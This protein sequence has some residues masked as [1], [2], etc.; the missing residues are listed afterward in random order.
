MRPDDPEL[1]AIAEAIAD[2]DHV[3]WPSMQKSAR[4]HASTVPLRELKNVAAIAAAFRRAYDEGE[5]ALASHSDI[6]LGDV[7]A[8]AGRASP[9]KPSGESE[10][11]G[12]LIVLERIAGGAFGTVYRAWDPALDHEVALKRV[13]VSATMA[14]STVAEVVREG[15]LLA[16]V[17]HENVITVHGAREMD[18]EI[19]IWMDF[20]HGRTLDQI[21]KDDGPLSGEEAIVMA[22]SL[23][24]A[25]AAVH[26]ADLLHRDIKAA[27]VMRESGGRIVML[28]FGAGTDLSTGPEAGRL[29]GTPLYMAPELF[30]RQP[31]SIRSD[32]YSL[33][34]LLFYLVTGRYP[35]VGN[36]FEAIRSAHQAGRSSHLSDLRA[37]L[38]PRFVQVVERALSPDPAERFASAGSMR[39]Q[40]TMLQEAA[41]AY[42]RHV[43]RFA[44][45]AGVTL[46][47][48]AGAWWYGG[49]SIPQVQHEPVSVVIADFQ[50]H[51]KNPVFDRTLEPFL[52]MVLEGAKFVSAYDRARITSS[53]GM[54]SPEILD[55]PAA[56]DIAVKQGLGVVL[57]GS[58]EP[59]GSGYRLALRAIHAVTGEVIATAQGTAADDEHVLSEATQLVTVVR[60]ALGDNTSD[61]AQLFAMASLSATSLEVLQHYAA[62]VEAASNNKFEEARRSALRA[63]ELDPNFGVGWQLLAVYSRNLG[64]LQDAEQYIKEALRH[65][66]GMTE[67]ERF[68][69]RGFFY[70]LTGDY[71]Q[72][73]KEY[74][75]LSARYAGDVVA[76]NQIALCASQLRELSR[77]QEEMRQAVELLPNRA[78]F[79]LNLALY[80]NYAGDFRPGNQQAR[81]VQQ[82]DSYALLAVAFSQLGQGQLA[83]AHGTYRELAKI[84]ALGTSLAASG[85]GDLATL[86]GRFSDAARILGQGADQDLASKNPDRAAAKFASLAFAQISRGQKD[87][88]VAAAEAA[89][90]NSKAVK[91]RFLA[92]R[93]LVESGRIASA[94][95]LIA[96]LASELHAE[97]QAYAK[98]ADGLISLEGDDPRQ[99][100]KVFTEA[101]GLLDTWIG[102]YDLGRAYLEAGQFA[103]ADSEFDRC[104]KRR[105]EALSLFLDEEPTYGYFP[106]VHYYQGRAREGLNSV[107]FA[108]SYRTYLSIRGNSNEDTLVEEARRRVAR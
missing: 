16:R 67:R 74:G 22:E 75:D 70:R 52:R 24:K 7:M 2:G 21:V 81:R 27:N 58:L 83:E 57:S 48:V 72:C 73:V 106:I 38:P 80:A 71:Q 9:A 43:R 20:V 49:R 25:L 63:V 29:A 92:A 4:S 87:Q 54:R 6:S 101:N 62:S 55:E 105:G 51:T 78:L 97:P 90:A 104:I 12:P 86:E 93:A 82:P 33:G 39:Q 32:I 60:K 3:D 108:D 11:W 107:G 61:S 17:R 15:Q 35:V 41:P 77:A 31:A 85:L 37:D 64:R 45:A 50:N 103:Q 56:R 100:I 8:D 34:V 44:V 19:G 36:T 102:H 79:R 53:L 46:A 84:D 99:A 42:R 18:G 94:Q 76:H 28:D 30:H 47:F 5:V 96:G 59:S 88:A 66:E 91:I 13:R 98:I 10:R 26:R 95:P 1:I 68:N 23:C 14:Q 40:L 65:L 89:L 69:S